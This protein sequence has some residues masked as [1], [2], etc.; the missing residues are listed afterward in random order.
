M[1][2]YENYIYFLCAGKIIQFSYINLIYTFF[3]K[4]YKIVLERTVDNMFRTA[5][6]EKIGKH[7]SELINKK[8]KSTREFCKEYLK[9]ENPEITEPTKDEIDKKANKLSQIKQG[10]AGIQIEDLGYFSELLDVS[11]EEILSAKEHPASNEYR[12]TNYNFA[13]SD[14]EDYW[15]H[16]INRDDKIILN[17]DEY[18]MTVVDY[19]IKFKNYNLLKYLIDKKY[20][21]FFKENQNNYHWSFG[22]GTSIKSNPAQANTLNYRLEYTDTLRT[23]M[24]A[25]AMENHDFKM[26]EYLHARETPDLYNAC[27]FTGFPV[28]FEE[29]YNDNMLKHILNSTSD[30]IDYFTKSFTVKNADKEMTCIFPYTEQLI[31]KMIRC[32]SKY[33]AQALRNAVKH[34]KWAL[35][36]LSKMVTEAFYSPYYSNCD[37]ETAYEAATGNFYM[38]NEGNFF[39]YSHLNMYPK[40]NAKY[41]MMKTN[42]VSISVRSKNPEINTLIDELNEVFTYITELNQDKLLIRKKQE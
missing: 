1:V 8:F 37:E 16:F 18:G 25:L 27:F 20:I 28:K 39:L 36:T 34:N 2:I 38:H 35:N 5:G 40:E 6:N 9:L 14:S 4:R 29:N 33:T 10:K 42:I 26:L 12:Y 41:M 22:A 30:V 32:N 21:W 19:A 13:L 3:E 31:E 23:D 11:C 7:I 15:K 24:A 17:A